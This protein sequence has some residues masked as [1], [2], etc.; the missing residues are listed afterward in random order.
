[1]GRYRADPCNEDEDVIFIITDSFSALTKDQKMHALIQYLRHL[2]ELIEK[3]YN[4]E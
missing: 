4:E 2:N 3:I 1:M